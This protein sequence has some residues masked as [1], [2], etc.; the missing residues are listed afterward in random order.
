M[1]IYMEVRQAGENG[2]PDL[3]LVNRTTTS[4][5]PKKG[6]LGTLP[7]WNEPDPVDDAE[8]ARN[9][10]AFGI[11]KTAIPSSTIRNSYRSFSAALDE[12][13]DLIFGFLSISR[14]SR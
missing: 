12:P 6:D 11:R 2:E 3:E 10:T 9:E 1:L 4:C 5:S 8:Q 14:L 7:L 13:L